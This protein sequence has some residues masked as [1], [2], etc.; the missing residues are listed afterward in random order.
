MCLPPLPASVRTLLFP[1][2]CR[3]KIPFS[4]RYR[5]RPPSTL[6]DTHGFPQIPLVVETKR[7]SPALSEVEQTVA[8]RP[9][10]E[11]SDTTPVDDNGAWV[12]FVGNVSVD[13]FP[14]KEPNTDLR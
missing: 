9:K 5:K 11:L 2:L 4:P 13:A 1:R 6:R 12:F 14:H 3:K 8:V 7:L 10:M